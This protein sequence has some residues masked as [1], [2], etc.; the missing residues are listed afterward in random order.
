MAI[1][2]L[3][4]QTP[5]FVSPGEGISLVSS[6]TTFKVAVHVSELTYSKAAGTMYCIEKIN[7][8]YFSQCVCVCVRAL[9]HIC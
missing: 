9:A 1:G 3:N 7:H 2:S 6:H 5:I 8:F 4:L